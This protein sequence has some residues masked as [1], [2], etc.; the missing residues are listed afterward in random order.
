LD[1]RFFVAIWS[2]SRS[3]SGR[4]G[5]FEDTLRTDAWPVHNVRALAV[6]AAPYGGAAPD[7]VAGRAKYPKGYIAV[8]TIDAIN[9]AL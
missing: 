9:T 3:S 4:V 8:R 5:G 6:A 7:R 2:T 1:L